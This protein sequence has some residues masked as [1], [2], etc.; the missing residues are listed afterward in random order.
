DDHQELQD[1]LGGDVR[2]DAQG[3]DGHVGEGAPGE[4]VDHGEDAFADAGEAVKEVADATTVD[5]GDGDMRADAID[6]EHA[7]GEEDLLAKIGDGEDGLQG[8]EHDKP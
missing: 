1:D 3:H 5:E 4:H 7:N 8:V 2:H 6:G